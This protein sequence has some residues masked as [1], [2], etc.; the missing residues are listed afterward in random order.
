MPDRLCCCG[1]GHPAVYLVASHATHDIDLGFARRCE[2][3]Y[4]AAAAH[5]ASRCEQCTNDTETKR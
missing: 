1:C 2:D 5:F 3:K 4:K